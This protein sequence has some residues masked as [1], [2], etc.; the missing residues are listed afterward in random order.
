MP[1]AHQRKIERNALI[2]SLRKEGLSSERIA[3]EVAVRTGERISAQRVAQLLK[4][5]AAGPAPKPMPIEEFIEARERLGMTRVEAA[6]A[7]G[8]MDP[9]SVRDLERKRSHVTGP[10]AMLMRVLLADLNEMPDATPRE[11][12]LV[13]FL[14]ALERRVAT[15][16]GLML[17]KRGGH[18]VARRE[19]IEPV[20]VPRSDLD[21][22]R[23]MA[24]ATEPVE[25]PAEAGALQVG[26]STKGRLTAALPPLAG[27][28]RRKSTSGS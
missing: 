20:D 21:E 8:F 18:R 13:G 23:V 17:S 10:A 22:E 6:L 25:Q 4:A 7:L 3:D 5:F 27:R 16:E 19:A 2:V 26:E 14:R 1:M 28:G 15:L 12:R 24:G 11:R 9:D